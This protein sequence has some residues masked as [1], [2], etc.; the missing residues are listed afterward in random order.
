MKQSVNNPASLNCKGA[1]L[2]QLSHFFTTTY[3]HI[4]KY[5]ILLGLVIA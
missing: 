1:H 4:S 3:P 2:R 5:H